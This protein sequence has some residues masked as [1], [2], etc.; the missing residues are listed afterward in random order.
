[1]I[2]VDRLINLV[3]YQKH[4]EIIVTSMN[5]GKNDIYST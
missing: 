1:M 2:F 4:M 5:S 3:Y